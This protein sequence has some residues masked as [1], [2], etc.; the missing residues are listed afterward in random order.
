MIGV[1]H[2]LSQEFANTIIDNMN[3]DTIVKFSSNVILDAA[4]GSCECVA[5]I[6]SEQAEDVVNTFLATWYDDD[7]DYFDIVPTYA[8]ASKKL[9]YNTLRPFFD[10]VVTIHM[11]DR[12]RYS[13]LFKKDRPPDEFFKKI[14]N[15]LSRIDDIENDSIVFIV[16]ID[17]IETAYP[18]ATIYKNR[19][20]NIL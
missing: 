13:M 7:F 8:F 6:L 2:G 15:I 18:I 19:N 20:N 1:T 16:I 5:D 12:M 17:L 9:G 3:L 11:H 10:Q 4:N 14:D